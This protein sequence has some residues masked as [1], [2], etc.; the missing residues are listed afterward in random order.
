M[1]E[2]SNFRGQF[3]NHGSSWVLSHLVD[4]GRL[5]GKRNTLRL[6]THR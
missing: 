6:V 1:I 5:P 2:I 3:T 4:L